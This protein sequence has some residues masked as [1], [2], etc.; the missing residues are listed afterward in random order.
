MTVCPSPF[1]P[2]L[3]LA[4]GLFL[5]LLFYWAKGTIETMKYVALLRGVNV[6]G[7]GMISMITLRENFVKAGFK[8]VSTYINS[9][10]VF[11][12][13]NEKDARKLEQKIETLL[14]K[15]HDL[16]SR[17]IIRSF[18]EIERLVKKLPKAWD[19]DKRWR[20]NIIFLS[21]SIDSKKIV[22][23][24]HPK[25]DIE[26]VAYLPGTLIWSALIKKLTQT[27]ML[28]FSR[29]EMYKE[30]TVRNPNTLRKIYELMKEDK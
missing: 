8:N 14:T 5:Y 29:A 12:S 13:S 24:L 20:R 18:S 15:K 1:H 22:E 11:F 7:N 3:L 28:K 21:H 30:V 23:E 16:K 17:V 9:G 25:P 26:T 27:T 19:A 2:D 10:N 4:E 6:G